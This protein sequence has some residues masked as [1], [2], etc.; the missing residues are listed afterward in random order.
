MKVIQHAGVDSRMILFWC[1]I[2]QCETSYY[3]PPSCAGAVGWEWAATGAGAG[4]SAAPVTSGTGWPACAG[5]EL[6]AG[7]LWPGEE[8]RQRCYWLVQD[9]AY[10]VRSILKLNSYCVHMYVRLSLSYV[11][12]Y[13]YSSVLY[14]ASL[15]GLRLQHLL[16]TCHSH[17]YSNPNLPSVCVSVVSSHMLG[18]HAYRQLA[19]AQPLPSENETIS[20]LIHHHLFSTSPLTSLSLPHHCGPVRGTVLL[21]RCLSFVST[22]LN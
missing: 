5:R 22:S 12:V 17:T 6:Q 1:L 4:L 7:H 3:Y 11:I 13:C 14:T 9:L 2:V 15:A 10:T 19:L 21:E 20:I 18:E 8:V 16:W